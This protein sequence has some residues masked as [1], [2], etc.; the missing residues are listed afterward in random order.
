[1][2][3][4]VCA[5]GL[6]AG[7]AIAAAAPAGAQT[8][9]IGVVDTFSGAQASFGEYTDKGFRL[10][11]KLHR[12]DLPNGVRIELINR[13]DGGLNPDRSKQLAQ[14]LVTRDRVD[15]LAG[16]SFTPNGMAT[17]AV[18]DQA[19][20]PFAI[21]NAATPVVTAKFP[22][23]VR[24]SFTIVQSVVPLGAWAAKHY[25]TAYTLVS[26]Y[27]P[28]WDAEKAFTAAFKA[29]GGTV[30]GSIR[31]PVQ[32]ADYSP[33]LQR[34]KDAKPQVVMIFVPG[35]RSATTVMKAFADIGLARAGAKL[36][37][38]GESI[39]PDDE[40]PNMGDAALG[41]ATVTHY[42]AA[43]TRPA[44]KAFVAAWK[45]EYGANTVP[46]FVGVAAWDAM[47]AIFQAIKAQHGKLEPE[48]TLDLLRHYKNPN[49]PRGP[50]AIDPAT[51][52]IVQN[53]YLHV[54][55]RVN[56]RLENVELGT[57]ATAVDANGKSK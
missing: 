10:Y 5:L 17:A 33:Y 12:K 45:K 29:A 47:D 15:L 19:K 48:K 14:E 16:G 22:Y 44:N 46:N 27:A 1:M 28:G 7:A 8:V 39:V 11:I 32:D 41:V 35:G 57:I 6:I 24:F 55:R 56:G 37:G 20:I 2:K 53:E 52:D 34:I 49:S 42:S 9:K 40:L 26:D 31:T 25:K 23:A 54:V 3:A 30:L 18:A 50:I 13:D 4:L 38:S 43:A 21:T 51:R 36:I